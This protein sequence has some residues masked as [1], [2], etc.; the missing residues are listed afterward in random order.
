MNAPN[1]NQTNTTEHSI[2]I[3]CTPQANKESTP[4]KSIY[5]ERTKKQLARPVQNNK[6]LYWKC[7]LSPK[8]MK[9]KDAGLKEAIYS[10]QSQQKPKTTVD[11][12]QI[13]LDFLSSNYRN[14]SEKT[15]CWA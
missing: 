10:E 3:K 7:P 1:I 11:K 2:Y 8:A 13:K 4:K 6:Y 5:T 9:N 14:R 15:H 12:K